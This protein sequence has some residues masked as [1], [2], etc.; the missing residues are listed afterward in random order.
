MDNLVVVVG[1][2]RMPDPGKVPVFRVMQIGEAA[3]DQRADEIQCQCGAL[4]TAQNHLRIGNPVFSS[5]RA[6]IDEI[7][8]ET[9]QGCSFACL[10]VGRP[11]LGVLARHTSYTNDRLLQPVQH[12]QAHL[13]K[14]LELVDDVLGRT[15]VKG[16]GAVAALQYEGVT[17]LCLRNQ[18]LE[19]IDLPGRHERRQAAEVGH[20]TFERRGVRI[21][22]LLGRRLRLPAGRMPLGLC[23]RSAHNCPLPLRERRTMPCRG[24]ALQKFLV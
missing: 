24:A 6:A 13:Q 1:H 9:R 16:L 19:R 7:A 10:D 20:D 2:R 23:D 15:L 5:E 12:H 11:R 21:C 22:R 3:V 17:A 14:D 8:A 4:I 18:L